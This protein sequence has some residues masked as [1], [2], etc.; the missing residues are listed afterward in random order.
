MS[1]YDSR[2]ER[3]RSA[4]RATRQARE[5]GEEAVL[6]GVEGLPEL[7]GCI[8]RVVGREGERLLVRL[9][10]DEVI[11]VKEGNLRLSSLPPPPSQIREKEESREGGDILPSWTRRETKIGNQQRGDVRWKREE[12]ALAQRMSL[13]SEE[14]RRGTTRSVESSGAG[15]GIRG[16]RRES[17]KLAEDKSDAE[18]IREE[19]LMTERRREEAL[20]AERRRREEALM[21]E[22]RRREDE[23]ERRRRMEKR[24]E[25]MR[26]ERE[27]KRRE[28]ARREKENKDETKGALLIA[29]RKEDMRQKSLERGRLKGI[30]SRPSLNGVE[31]TILTE[32][33]RGRVRVRV[34]E[35]EDEGKHLLLLPSKV[36]RGGS[37]ITKQKKRKRSKGLFDEIFFFL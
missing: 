27:E 18:R 12:K 37:G 23:W 5:G 25:E 13:P 1:H 22:R 31:V 16:G 20:A 3:A 35:G 8:V 4:N 6:R 30:A 19:A 11:K 26:R 32:G 21:T 34:E 29:T 14:A 17:E 2:V 36:E 24:K 7:D 28:E 10:D 33:E 9:P 15:V